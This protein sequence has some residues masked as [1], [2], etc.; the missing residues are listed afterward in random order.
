[1]WLFCGNIGIFNVDLA[2][3]EANAEI[4]AARESSFAEMKGSFAEIHDDIAEILQLF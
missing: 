1:M 4:N 3:A 2:C